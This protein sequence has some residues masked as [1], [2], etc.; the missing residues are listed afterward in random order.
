[1]PDPQQQDQQIEGLPPGAIVRPI[2]PAQQQIQ[3]LPRGAIVRTIQRAAEPETSRVAQPAAAPTFAQSHPILSSIGDALEGAEKGANNT[4]GLYQ[5]IPKDRANRSALYKI[6]HPIIPGT[7]DLAQSPQNTAQKIGYGG[8]QAAEFLAPGEAEEEAGRIAAKEFPKAAKYAAPAARIAAGALSTGGINKL[9][10]GS[11]KTGAGAGAVL[12]TVGEAARAVAPALAESALGV[13][14]KI[15]GFGRTPGEAALDEIKGVRPGTVGRNAQAK[16]SELTA[17]L[18]QRAATS[19][20][21]ASTNPAVNVIDT[22][23]IKA[24]RQNNRGYYDQLHALREQLTRDMATGEKFPAQMPASRILDLKRGVGN[25]E[26]GWSPEQRGAMRGTIRKV[27]AALD[28]ELDRAVPGAKEINQRISSLIP[29]AQRG[30]S[31]ERGAG[32]AQRVQHRMAVHTGALAGA[33]AGGAYEK[34]RGHSPVLGAAAGL[35]IPELA[36]SPVAEMTAARLM[37]SGTPPRMIR[38]LLEN[39]ARSKQGSPDEEGN[40]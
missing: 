6:F 33:L 36:A 4:L 17:E 7:S 40:R 38:G 35:I 12:G 14:K 3:G 32:L 25:L 2:R 5:P 27:Y 34:S 37:R 10:G 15:R 31:V 13:T 19:K 28:G 8:E 39:F 30:A 20:A 23:Q 18:E 9:Q 24:L 26:K 1:M 16:A 22:E 21:L 11:F 29:V